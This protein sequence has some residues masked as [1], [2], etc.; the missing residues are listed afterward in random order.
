[1]TQGKGGI[2]AQKPIPSNRSAR[3]RSVK[4]ANR[5]RKTGRPAPDNGG[6]LTLECRLALLN[7]FLASLGEAGFVRGFSQIVE[8]ALVQPHGSVT[9]GT[10]DGGETF[11]HVARRTENW[12]P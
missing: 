6:L 2:I 11:F 12:R 10:R 3:P 4:V 1:M 8:F 7:L 5:L 9:K